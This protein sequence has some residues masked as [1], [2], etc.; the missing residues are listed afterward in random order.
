M[1]R[2][3][4][5]R[6]LVG[7]ADIPFSWP[8]VR[9]DSQNPPLRPDAAHPT[10]FASSS[11]IL[12][13]RHPLA[14]EQRGPQAGVAAADDHEVGGAAPRS[15]G[16]SGRGCGKVVRA[17]RPH[18]GSRSEA[19]AT[20]DA[21]GRCRSKTVVPTGIS[22]PALGEAWH[23]GHQKT[24]RSRVGSAP[25][26]PPRISVPHRRQGLPSRRYTQ[27]VRPGR[28]SP[29]KVRS[30]RSRLARIM[31]APRSTR[32]AASVS[33]A[34]VVGRMPRTKRISLAYSLPNPAMLR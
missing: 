30:T 5:R 31:R 17:R 34:G 6:H 32:A 22:F 9:L 8:W 3:C 28:V 23:E 7:P 33:F 11:T 1:P 14:R 26:A 27:V 10:R 12:R 24:M 2:R 4:E 16:R 29:V 13:A 25:S 15:G 20:T 21:A 18:D 19:V